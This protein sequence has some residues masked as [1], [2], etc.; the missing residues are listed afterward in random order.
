MTLAK[1]AIASFDVDAQK[2]FT[3]LCPNELPVVGGDRIGAELNYMAS[4][5]GHRVGSKDA[6]TP[7]APWVVAQHSEM[8][9]PT[10]LAHADVTWV[11]HCVPGTEGFT[12]LDELPTPYDYDYFIWKGVEPDLHPYGACYHDLHDKLS[13][14][15][16]EYLR[17]HG[18]VRVIV[19]GLA[20]DY[21]VKTTALQLL[22]A[23]LEVVLH[24]PACR[25]I[26]EEGGIQALNELRK[27]GAAISSTREELAAMA[28]R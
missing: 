15:V 2:S 8:L 28:T 1:T 19:G 12:L 10:G 9:Q 24:V 22:K 11:S 3:P 7:H 27:A 17:A 23:G 13:T 21:C 6:H 18:V 14:G 20:L 25:G 26:S 5:A 16:I 4:L